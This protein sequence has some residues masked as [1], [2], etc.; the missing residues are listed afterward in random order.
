MHQHYRQP[1]GTPSHV[2][3]RYFEKHPYFPIFNVNW[4]LT[5]VDAT[6]NQRDVLIGFRNLIG[7]HTGSAQ[8]SFILQTIREYNYETQ[9]NCFIGDSAMSNDASLIAGL[10]TS[11]IIEIDDSHR[12][13]CAGHII[14]L[15]V[16]ATLYGS[17]VSKFE[18]EL[19]QEGPVE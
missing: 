9:L 5:L 19:P 2:S 15:I 8:A 6:Y 12:I 14:N 17:G 10:N 1:A 13:S 7:D 16:K 18:E 3:T 4:R 11:D